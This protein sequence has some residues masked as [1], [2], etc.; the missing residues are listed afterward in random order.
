M[1]E[2]AVTGDRL[3]TSDQEEAERHRVAIRAASATARAKNEA[4]ARLK[5]EDRAETE[6]ARA[7]TE[8]ARAETEAA[9]RREA[10]ARAETEAAARREAE[11]EL[12]RL[13]DELAR[14]SR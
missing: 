7:E 14:R 13:R 3:L 6:A 5:A 4:A 1:L 8:A 10:E 2:D 11:A 9:A 12:A